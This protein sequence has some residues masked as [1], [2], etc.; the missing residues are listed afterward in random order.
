MF[1]V[2]NLN[3]HDNR[4]DHKDKYGLPGAEYR[5]DAEI[6][7]K[8]S[9]EHRITSMATWPIGHQMLGSRS[10]LVSHCI[11]RITLTVNSHIYNTPDSQRQSRHQSYKITM[12]FQRLGQ[13]LSKNFAL[14]RKCK[15]NS[16]DDTECRSKD[17]RI[18]YEIVALSKKDNELW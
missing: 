4:Y 6:I 12:I 14:S 1:F 7:N 16:F 15:G 10:N 5:E 9:A 3:Q 2:V 11:K 8:S 17:G 18:A 13:H